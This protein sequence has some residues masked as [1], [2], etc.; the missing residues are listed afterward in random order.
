MQRPHARGGEPAVIATGFGKVMASNE[1]LY[2][3]RAGTAQAQA[4]ANG[5]G[6]TNAPVR[7][8]T[9]DLDVPAFIRKKVD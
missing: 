7:G 2:A 3:L 1:N 9:A 6:Q 8:G 5:A 4:R